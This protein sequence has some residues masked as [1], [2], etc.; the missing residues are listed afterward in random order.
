MENQFSLVKPE[1]RNINNNGYNP[2]I[3][4]SYK[5]EPHSGFNVHCSRFS[6]RLNWW[7]LTLIPFGIILPYKYQDK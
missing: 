6:T 4:N 5:I 1:G 2:L 7:W 3:A